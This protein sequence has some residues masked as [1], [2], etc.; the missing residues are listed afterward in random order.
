MFGHWNTNAQCKHSFHAVGVESF[1]G[2]V[3]C[4]GEPWVWKHNNGDCTPQTSLF[5]WF[6]LVSTAFNFQQCRWLQQFPMTWAKWVSGG[7]KTCHSVTLKSDSK[8][9]RNAEWAYWANLHMATCTWHVQPTDST[10]L[11]FHCKMRIS[12]V[13][14]VRPAKLQGNKQQKHRSWKSLLS[15]CCQKE[16]K[17]AWP[18]NHLDMMD[19]L[20]LTRNLTFVTWTMT[21]PIRLP[22][23]TALRH[24]EG[25]DYDTI[26]V[27]KLNKPCSL[28]DGKRACISYHNTWK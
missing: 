19:R 3:H 17:T 18:L 25:H 5:E 7:S 6:N 22:R 20:K 12:K 8:A 16:S 28:G 1:V 21:W 14:K 10:H 13:R 27:N 23:A 2:F 4:I 15:K 26:I 11:N 9:H 24:G